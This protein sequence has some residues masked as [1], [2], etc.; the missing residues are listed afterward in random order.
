M[1]AFQ[2]Y[3]WLLHGAWT[4]AL[5]ERGI[6]VQTARRFIQLRQKYCQNGQLVRFDSV[7]AALSGGKAG[8]LEVDHLQPLTRAVLLALAFPLIVLSSSPIL[9]SPM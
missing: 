9:A 6:P 3:A 4:P 5:E 7:S 2:Q 1:R 8:R